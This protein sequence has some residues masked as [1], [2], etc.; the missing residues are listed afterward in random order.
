MYNLQRPTA[1]PIAGAL[2][3]MN[4]VTSPCKSSIASFPGGKT[5]TTS[6]LQTDDVARAVIAGIE[7]NETGIFDVEGIQKLSLKP[8]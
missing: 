2:Q 5:L 7:Y 8:L 3:F 6:P 1:M 4:A